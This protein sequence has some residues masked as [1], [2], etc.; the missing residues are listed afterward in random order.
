MFVILT[1]DVNQ[2][3]VSKVMRTCRKYL[4]HVQN[5]VFEGTI[6]GA[7]LNQLKV[8]LENKID[9]AVDRICVYEFDSTRYSRREQIG[10]TEEISNIID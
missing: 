3:R 8:E 6:T 10:A 1:Y 5:S 4:F 2:K 9:K 7:K